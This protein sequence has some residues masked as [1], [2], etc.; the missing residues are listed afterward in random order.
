MLCNFTKEEYL[1][2]LDRLYSFCDEIRI[3]NMDDENYFIKEVFKLK[4][5]MAGRE[6]FQV[7]GEKTI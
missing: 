7:M 2:F 4:K 3:V 1:I 5:N 6:G